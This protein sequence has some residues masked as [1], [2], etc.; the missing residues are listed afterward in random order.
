[1]NDKQ[2]AASAA[3]TFLVNNPD[4]KMMVK[5]LKYYSGLPEVDMK[6]IINFEAKVYV[7]TH[8]T[9]NNKTNLQDYVYL[10]T[11]GSDAYQKKDWDTAINNMEESLASYLHAEDECRAQCEGPFDPGWYPDFVPAIAS[12]FF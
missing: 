3:F 10:Y 8:S 12:I 5:N 7:A 6:D 4:D 2:K 9:L 1:M 11:Y